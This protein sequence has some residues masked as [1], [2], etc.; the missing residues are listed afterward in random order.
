ML[1]RNI[2]FMLVVCFVL[3]F[4]FVCLEELDV[5]VRLHELCEQVKVWDEFKTKVRRSA[6]VF[7]FKSLFFLIYM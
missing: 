3:F 6:L 1:G 7:I 2:I 4:P 5:E